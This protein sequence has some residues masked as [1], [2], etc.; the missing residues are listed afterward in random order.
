M[1]NS[2]PAPLNC[3]PVMNDGRHGTD[4][5]PI[6]DINLKLQETNN[7]QNSND[8]RSFLV[9]NATAIMQQ[10]LKQFE[11]TASCVPHTAA[12]NPNGADAVWTGYDE[13]VKYSPV[14]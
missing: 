12:V 7:L 1:N 9:N 5:R 11:Q 8:Y 4:Y 2:T 13:S 3:P 6:A 10:N 14:L